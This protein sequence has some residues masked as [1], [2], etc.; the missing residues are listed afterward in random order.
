MRESHRAGTT[1]SGGRTSEPFVSIVTPSL[2]QAAFIET[3]IASVE[4]QDYPN[5]E[6][7]VIDGGSSDGTIAVLKKHPHLDWLSE[8]DGGQSSAINK[9]FRRVRGEI[10][11]WLNSD[12]VYNAGAIREA[13]A[14]LVTHPETALVYGDY[15]EIDSNG[16]VIDIV[17]VREFDLEY[18][19]NVANI[20]PQPSVFFRRSILDTVGFLSESYHYSFDVEY[21]IRIAR[22][23]LRIDH[24]S[25]VWSGFRRHSSS[26]TSIA[27]VLFWRE[28]RAIRRLY[29]GR[30]FSRAFFVYYRNLA[31]R[32]VYRSMRKLRPL[33]PLTSL[34]RRLVFRKR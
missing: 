7:I 34:I 25:S 32:L 6:H 1:A 9:G 24:V 27:P 33:R 3:T 26:K 10:I 8:P 22:A 14:Y 19:L 29:G 2:N 15:Q 13:V 5:V 4:S 11:G 16:A 30:Y 23:G 20:I 21:W 28:D 12:D 17:R 18:E 31:Y